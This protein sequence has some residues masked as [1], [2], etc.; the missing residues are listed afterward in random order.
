MGT[1]AVTS[2]PA[3]IDCGA[4]CTQDYTAHTVV[5]LT[6]T[7]DADAVFA[8]WAGACTNLT[9]DCVVTMNAAQSVEAKFTRTFTLTVT[10]DP[11][12]TGTGRVT[13][14]PAGIDC[15][16]SGQAACSA[17]YTFGT[18]VT[19]TAT[20]GL[21]S[22]FAGWTAGACTGTDPACVLEMISDQSAQ[23]RF[24]LLP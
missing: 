16:A 4:D 11:A 19:L 5:T 8:G 18:A 2:S 24:D 22:H 15:T 7:P 23:A 14:N 3:G 17:V 12:G 21:L 9:G 6:A 13:S 10:V 1:G 20:E